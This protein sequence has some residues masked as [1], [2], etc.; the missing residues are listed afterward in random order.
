M[1]ERVA[2]FPAE[3]LEVGE[4]RQAHLPDGTAIALYNVEGR[5]YATDDCCSHGAVS[6]S[7]EGSLTGA[8]VECSW[9]FGTFDVTTGAAMGMPCELPLKT[10]PVHIEN[11]IIHVEV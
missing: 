5:I 1:A 9:H 3:E 10:Y 2:F 11:G 6:L 8:V 7:E 4:M